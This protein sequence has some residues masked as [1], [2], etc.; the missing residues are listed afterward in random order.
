MQK[1]SS[2]AVREIRKEQQQVR[3]VCA[4]QA[5]D[6]VYRY[7]GVITSSPVAHND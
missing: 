5:K 3:C 4:V 2:L 7:A 1:Y 6:A